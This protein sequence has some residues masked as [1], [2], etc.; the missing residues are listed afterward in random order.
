MCLIIKTQLKEPIL[1]ACA[2]EEG[3]ILINAAVAIPFYFPKNTPPGNGNI[4]LKK[5][6]TDLNSRMERNN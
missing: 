4:G 3:S 6:L 5:W 2:K 1:A